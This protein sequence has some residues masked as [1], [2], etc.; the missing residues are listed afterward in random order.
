MVIRIEPCRWCKSKKRPI[1]RE[2]RCDN[3]DAHYKK[4][5]LSSINPRVMEHLNMDSVRKP[6]KYYGGSGEFKRRFFG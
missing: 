1:V 4:Y 2:G 3:C 5:A 6:V